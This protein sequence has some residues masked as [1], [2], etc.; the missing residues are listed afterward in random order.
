VYLV[1]VEGSGINAAVQATHAAKVLER[2]LTRG[3]RQSAEE[4]L[5]LA[6]RTMVK[7]LRSQI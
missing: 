2:T 1:D 6:D 3:D 4:L 5:A 7:E